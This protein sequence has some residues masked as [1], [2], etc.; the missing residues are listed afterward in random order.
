MNLELAAKRI[1]RDIE[2]LSAY[3]STPGN[4]TTR[5]P[6]TREA[7][8]GVDYLRGAMEDAGLL[9][10]ED[11]AGNIIGVLKG[12]D[13]GLPAIVT[14]SHF[15]TVVNGGNFD[16]LAGVVAGLEMAR[17][18]RDEGI[19]LK[20]DFVVIGFCDEEGMRFG[21]GFFGSK[22]ILGQMTVEELHRFKD[23]DGVSVYEAMKSYG[24]TPEKIGTAA[25]DLD[26]IKA[27][28][29]LHI[30][31]GP[32]LDTRKI[33][34]GL[35][36]CIVGMQRYMVTVHGRPDHA[37][38]TPMD[39]R[40]DA[41]DVAAKV[42]S[43]IGDWAR[44]KGDG[45]VGTTGFMR[46]A[47]CAMN[48]VAETCEFSIDVRSVNNDNIKDIVGK[49]K[50]A[51]GEECARA[52]AS[53]DWLEKLVIEPVRLDEGMLYRLERSCKDHGYSYTRLPSGA[54][55]DALAIGQAL[56]TVM[57]FAPS[58]DG[59]SHC[60]VEWTGYDA[61]AKATHVTYDLLKDMQE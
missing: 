21:T 43:R 54:G 46:V 37:G 35:V 49:I 6:F 33:D 41:V 28:I 9:A 17:L 38:T 22:S 42:V 19:T 4:G 32:V 23:K 52:G 61:L 44:E 1:K 55:H 27:F 12:E 24:K 60:P 15:D 59:R 45:T 40:I 51:L 14:G 10:R 11:E 39:M 56:P 18:L 48:I 36:D 58:K 29:E 5:L 20:R 13:S 7:R 25:W 16:G 3:T 34:I 26:K 8:A 53:Y 47:P 50:A 57:V 2:N 31:Q 30:E